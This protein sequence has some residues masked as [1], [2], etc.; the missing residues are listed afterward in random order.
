MIVDTT[1][2]ESGS[3]Q[4]ELMCDMTAFSCAWSFVVVGTKCGCD[5]LISMQRVRQEGI[6]HPSS[7]VTQSTMHADQDQSRDNFGL[8]HV[9]PI[10]GF[11][12]SLSA[13]SSA[14][15]FGEYRFLVTDPLNTKG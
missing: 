15:S 13:A 14:I 4:D 7:R 6:Y 2:S 10:G 3:L 12:L 1:R 5:G 9:L 8:H 11:S